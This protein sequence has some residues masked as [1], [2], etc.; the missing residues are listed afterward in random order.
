MGLSG[1]EC[2]VFI[3]MLMS[4]LFLVITI[5]MQIWGVWKGHAF[6]KIP[7]ICFTSGIVLTLLFTII[8]SI[9][10]SKKKAKNN[11]GTFNGMGNEP[12][13]PPYPY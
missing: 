13:P 10:M 12:Y 2:V 3:L 8:F 5:V 9:M 4:I 6:T 7:A 11:Q 1:G